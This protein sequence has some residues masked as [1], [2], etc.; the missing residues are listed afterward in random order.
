MSLS[1]TGS[2]VR[3]EKTLVNSATVERIRHEA[4]AKLNPARKGPLGQFMTPFK[5]ADFMASL[6]TPST[7]PAILLD[8]GAGIGSLTIAASERIAVE[9]VEVWEIDEVMR[10]F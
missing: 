4:N 6:F 1:S 5:I 8:A 9:R 3:V 7:Q 2:K 10:S